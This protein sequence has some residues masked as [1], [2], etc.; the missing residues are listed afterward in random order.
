MKIITGILLIVLTLLLLIKCK[1]AEDG[2]RGYPRLNTLTVTGITKIGA[3]LNAEIYFRS[4]YNILK[5]GFVWAEY[6]NPD[7]D[8][9]DRVI[10]SGNV[11]SNNFSAEITSTLKEGEIYYVR[12]FIVTKDYTVYG[13]NVEFLSLGSDAPV[14][15]NFSPHSG[16]WGDTIKITGRNFSFITDKN[17]VMLGS[18]NCN[19]IS[20]TD[21]VIII[22]IPSVKNDLS[23]KLNVSIVGNIA[24]SKESFTYL[25][26]Q[27]SSVSPLNGTYRDTILIYGK[28]FGYFKENVSV[29]I[30]GLVSNIVSTTQVTIKAI[31]PDNLTF[32]NNSIDVTASSR[33]VAYDKQFVLNA[34]VITAFS[35]DTA[36][37]PNAVIT[38]YGTNLSP[39]ANNN[40]VLIEG[41]NATITESGLNYIKVILPVQS[42]QNYNISVFKNVQMLVTIAGQTTAS[43]KNL[44]VSW[45]S[46]WTRKN[47]F[48]GATRH[49]AV[50]FALKGKGY[51]GTGLKESPVEYMKDFWEYDPV[52]DKWTQIADFPAGPR[53]AASAFTI[54]NKGYVG[55]GT[56]SSNHY[57]DFYSYDP[58]LG[59]WTKI[60]NFPGIGRYSAA[61]FVVNN[62]A[63]VGTGG[64]SDFWNYNPVSDTWNSEQNFPSKTSHA[65]GFN[66]ENKGYVY[67][68]NYL[69]TLQE[70]TWVRLTA[71]GLT[72]WDNIAF[73]IKN[74]AYFG[75]GLPHEVGGT[76]QLWEYNPLNQS[77]VRRDID[78]KYRRW[79]T[80]VFVLNN[81][82]YIIGGGTYD[83]ETVTLGDVW[84]FDPALPLIRN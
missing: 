33:S 37:K 43:S 15:N 42:I 69:Y 11:V 13:K 81:K 22:K 4:N 71:P 80:S 45:H 46:T 31:I 54:G 70:N 16:T 44:E 17:K 23:V 32:T 12:A 51:F 53:T 40:K 35:P 36:F 50:A 29:K 39:V 25:V 68:Y 52:N 48:P 56:I 82:A 60:A 66:I 34:P 62:I 57:N 47:D 6:E 59:I 67:N 73:S 9:S 26:P 21:T 18:V 78:Y 64:A 28:N 19:I 3:T 63:H 55:L 5:Y 74:L 7:L 24:T 1:K 2:D 76:N 61:S 20:T 27:I 79:G 14:V 72:A 49:N 65:V 8:R 41:Y 30:G 84:E 38:L 10:F 75:L 83:G 58:D 77:S